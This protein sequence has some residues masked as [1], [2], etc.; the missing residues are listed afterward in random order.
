[1]HEGSV[2]NPVQALELERMVAILRKRA[3][4]ANV[5]LPKDVA[6]YL[7]QNIRSS[8]RELEGALLRLIGYASMTGTAITL[9]Y[10]RQ[11]L[12]DLID[13]QGHRGAV[14]SFRKMSPEQKIPAEQRGTIEAHIRGQHRV[15]SDHVFGFWLQTR[16]GRN[17]RRVRHEL[18][19]NVRESERERLARWDAYERGLERRAKTRKQG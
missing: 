11:V 14:D 8:T 15:A 1:V 6:F 10:T 18:E 16:N 17:N 12:K 19:V 13:A 7:A 2:P 3:E 4:Q 9:T 5:T